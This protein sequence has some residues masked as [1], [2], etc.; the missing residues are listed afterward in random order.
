MTQ[1]ADIYLP[2]YTTKKRYC[3][4]TGGRG[5][6]K[7]TTVHDFICRLTYEVGHGVLFT[8]YTMTSAEKSIIPEFIIAITRLGIENDFYIT[9]NKIV[10]KRTDSFIIFSGIKTSS[11][12]QTANLKSIAGISTWVI[13]EGEDFND[14]KTF[15]TI[16]DSIRTTSVQN[17]V[18]W[19]Q[20]PSTKEH[21]IYK[22]FIKNTNKQIDIYGH[23]VTVST[24]EQVEHIHS[25]YLIAKKYLSKDWLQKA[26]NA[27]KNNPEWYYHNYI[28]G[29]LEKAEGVIYENH[30]I[31]D[32]PTWI[33]YVFAIDWGNVDPLAMVKVAVDNTQMIIYVDEVN[34]KPGMTLPEIERLLLYNVHPDELIV[35]DHNEGTT[36]DTLYDSGWNIR[37]AI[38]K[39][40]N[41]RIRRIQGY[42]IVSTEKSVNLRIELNNYTWHDKRSETPIDKFNHLI[43]AMEY[44]FEELTNSS[45][46]A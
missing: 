39:P 28:G 3:L 14:E 13:D 45:I 35:C 15:E 36:R 44:G 5:S 12:D 6:L 7:S 20:N 37:N 11:G 9:K 30:E 21:F 31:G 10:N 24:H 27:K 40:L 22:K 34:Y 1:I 18:I 4:L 32:F 42:K 25:T 19:I 46:F 38:K 16:D 43:N 17:R 26:E 33:P 2:L 41:D 8:R 23:K 29:W